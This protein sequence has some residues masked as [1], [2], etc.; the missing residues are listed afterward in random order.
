MADT[1]VRLITRASE[2]TARVRSKGLTKFTSD[3][4]T[5]WRVSVEAKGLVFSLPASLTR[6]SIGLFAEHAPYSHRVDVDVDANANVHAVH[7]AVASGQLQAP[8]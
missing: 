7:R 1:Q 2:R 3:T 5:P 6:M 4:F 8:G